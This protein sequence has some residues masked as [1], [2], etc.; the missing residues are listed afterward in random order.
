MYNIKRGR[1]SGKLSC[2]RDTDVLRIGSPAIGDAIHLGLWPDRRHLRAHLGDCAREVR[3]HDRR[4]AQGHHLGKAPFA[5]AD[6]GRV[7]ARRPHANQH[8]VGTNLGNRELHQLETLRSPIRINSDC[9]H[10]TFLS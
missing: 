8:V 2:S 1:Q 10:R 3:A 7:N 6:I 9:S 5:D 4:E